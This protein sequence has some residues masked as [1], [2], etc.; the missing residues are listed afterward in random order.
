MSVLN[1]D[2]QLLELAIFEEE[3]DEEEEEASKTTKR[4]S[5]ILALKNIKKKSFLYLEHYMMPVYT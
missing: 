3:E 2:K 1:Y 4:K 5:G